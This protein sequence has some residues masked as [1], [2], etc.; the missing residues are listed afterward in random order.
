[1]PRYLAYRQRRPRK[2]MFR[3]PPVHGIHHGRLYAKGTQCG[4]ER[5]SE[6]WERKRA[7]ECPH[8]GP[9]SLALPGSF[10]Q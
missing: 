7:R 9:I 5:M 8:L 1:M 10:A 6:V 3:F 4:D 2:R